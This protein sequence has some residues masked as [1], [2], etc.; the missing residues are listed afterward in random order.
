M[1]L[2]LDE[3]VPEVLGIVPATWMVEKAPVDLGVC[4]ECGEEQ[5][6]IG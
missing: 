5:K 4:Q 3:R 6:D 2:N 1:I